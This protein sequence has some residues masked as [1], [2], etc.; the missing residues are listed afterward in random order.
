ML[1]RNGPNR[2]AGTSDSEAHHGHILTGQQQ[3]SSIYR[4]K[5]GTRQPRET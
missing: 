2:L 3:K 1:V 4:H 5:L